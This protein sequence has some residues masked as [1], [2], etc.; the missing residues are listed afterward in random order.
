MQNSQ[1]FLQ[2]FFKIFDVNI[3]QYLCYLHEILFKTLFCCII[4][5]D[6]ETQTN[7]INQL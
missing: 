5:D 2:F 6:V 3:T 4:A 7:A 1:S